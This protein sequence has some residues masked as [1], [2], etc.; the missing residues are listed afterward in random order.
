M[1]AYLVNSS[2]VEPYERLIGTTALVLQ[3]FCEA[4]VLLRRWSGLSSRAA[5]RHFGSIQLHDKQVDFHFHEVK[6]QCTRTIFM[7]ALLSSMHSEKGATC[8]ITI[9]NYQKAKKVTIF[10]KLQVCEC[11]HCEQWI[12]V[13]MVMGLL[14]GSC[15]YFC[16]RCFWCQPTVVQHWYSK[17]WGSRHIHT[18]VRFY[19]ACFPLFIK[20]IT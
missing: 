18:L 3:D 12:Y 19:Y 6:F 15:F 20:Y 9:S 17:R 14:Q 4:G 1:S 13:W 5:R 8:L 2:F 10:S 7:N 16:S 11:V